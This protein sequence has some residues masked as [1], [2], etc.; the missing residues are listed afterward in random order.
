MNRLLQIAASVALAL[1]LGGLVAL[2]L[3]V[4]ALFREDR[5]LA[6]SAAPTLFNS[7]ATYQLFL[8][9]IGLI[10]LFF[11]RSMVRSRWISTIIVLF[12]ISLALAAYV[13][14]SMI[15]EM[16]AIRIGGQSGDSP[17]FK[18]LHGM[19]MI[20][21]TSQTIALLLA[22]MMIPLAISAD[23]V[24]R[25]AREAGPATR[26]PGDIADPVATR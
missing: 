26:S 12:I 8:G 6:I 16:E 15:P 10:A 2:F 3:F 7:F 1:W 25:T 23:A 9:M 19:S 11:W 24:S 4:G 13:M 14:F 22:A 5:T 17:R 18:T 21:Y 20:F